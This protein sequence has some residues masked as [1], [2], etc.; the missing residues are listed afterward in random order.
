MLPVICYEFQLKRF[1]LFAPSLSSCASTS[2]LLYSSD[3]WVVYNIFSA[4]FQIVGKCSTSSDFSQN[5]S[6]LLTLFLHYEMR[7]KNMH[8]I[9]RHRA[10]AKHQFIIVF[11]K[12][13]KRAKNVNLWH[14][15]CSMKPVKLMK[16][17]WL[18][19]KQQLLWPLF[20]QPASDPST[21]VTF[22]HKFSWLCRSRPALNIKCM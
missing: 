17:W 18:Q 15:R 8:D 20:V 7:T 21:C 11:K 4:V 19:L 14:L 3:S 22:F 10:F 13:A 2:V 5:F 6:S 12:Y 16:Y 1:S 9:D